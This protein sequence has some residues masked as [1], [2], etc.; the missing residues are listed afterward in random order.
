MFIHLVFLTVV[1]GI[2]ILYGFYPDIYF[3][4]LIYYLVSTFVFLQALSWTTSSVY[5]FFKDLKQIIQII[6]RIGFWFTPVFWNI[7]RVPAKY[8]IFIKAN[9]VY[10]LIAGY[11]DCLV[12]K[13]WFWEHPFLTLY[14]WTLTFLLLFVG[15]IIFRRL[16]PHFA[17]VM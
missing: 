10:Y 15:S 5:P 8:Q 16:K 17:D 9:P 11:R 2:F 7:D 12:Y 14:F 4:Q 1:I 13:K 6:V 3:L